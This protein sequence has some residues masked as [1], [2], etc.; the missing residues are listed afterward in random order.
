MPDFVARQSDFA[1]ITTA[2]LTAMPAWETLGLGIQTLA[3][4]RADVAMAVL[5]R[6]TFDGRHV[7]GGIVG[8]LLDIAGGAAA[9]TLVGEGYGVVTLGFE[10]HHL[11]PPG[12]ATLLARARVVKPGR[13]QA[14]SLVEIDTVSTDGTTR[15]CATGHV[16]SCWV[17][18]P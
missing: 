1:A 15:L 17:P 18:L 8:A 16:T 10:T 12:G 3:P 5:P 14:V 4:G 6:L 9:F 2:F 11:G 13:N 7:Q